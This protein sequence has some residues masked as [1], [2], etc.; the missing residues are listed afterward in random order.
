[1]VASVV[2]VQGERKR[3]EES[4][5]IYSLY[6]S[7]QQDEKEGNLKQSTF[8]RQGLVHQGQG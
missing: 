6:S 1:M 5:D 2:C 4:G 7:N 3:S 8:H